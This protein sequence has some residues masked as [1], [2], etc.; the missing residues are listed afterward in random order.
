MTGIGDDH[1]LAIDHLSNQ[2]A[3]A[4]WISMLQVV[5]YCGVAV[6]NEPRRRSHASAGDGEVYSYSGTPPGWRFRRCFTS[7]S[8][9]P[10]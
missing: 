1:A 10:W 6:I 2:E 8:M 9:P 7:W 3:F 4:A 5:K